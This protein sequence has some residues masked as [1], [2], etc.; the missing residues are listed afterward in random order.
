MDSNIMGGVF[1]FYWTVVLYRFC[2]GRLFCMFVLSSLQQLLDLMQLLRRN[3]Q[4]IQLGN[5]CPKSRA[6]PTT[7]TPPIRRRGRWRRIR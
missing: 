6:R 7:P 3:L 4:F 2:I 5:R 1:R